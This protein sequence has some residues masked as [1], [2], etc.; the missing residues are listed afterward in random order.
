MTQ[1]SPNVT[2]VCYFD[3]VIPCEDEIKKI[4]LY[5]KMGEY[6]ICLYVLGRWLVIESVELRPKYERRVSKEKSL[7]K[8][9]SDEMKVEFLHLPA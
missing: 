9:E 3:L 8:W 4:R 2:T 6:K 1:S 7:W 5:T